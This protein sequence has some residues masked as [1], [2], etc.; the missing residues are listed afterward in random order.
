MK[1]SPETRL[2]SRSSRK[3]EA[4]RT[5]PEKA[6]VSYVIT[7]SIPATFVIFSGGVSR[8]I[9]RVVELTPA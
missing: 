3:R 1:S 2:F 5:V 4:E 8:A 6:I 9:E 7:I